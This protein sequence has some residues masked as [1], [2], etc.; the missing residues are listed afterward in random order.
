MNSLGRIVGLEVETTPV[1][2]PIGISF[3]T[4]QAISYIVDLYLG[5][6]PVQRNLFSLGLYIAMFPQLVAGPIVRY[7]SIQ[8]EIENRRLSLDQI[9]IGMKLF[10]VGLFQKV[11]IADSLAKIVDVSLIN[12]QVTEF[13]TGM[14]WLWPISYSS[15]YCRRQE[16]AM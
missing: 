6:F 1:Y 13:T 5:K 16:R 3:F 9:I 7:K 8:T 10:C 15:V 14:A 11:I 4:F 2:L 12:T